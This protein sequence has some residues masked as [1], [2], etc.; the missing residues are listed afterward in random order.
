MKLKLLISILFISVI[1]HPMYSM[2]IQ[3]GVSYTIEQARKIAFRN[4]PIKI[5]M[6]KY[7][8][9]LIDKNFEKNKTFISKGELKQKKYILTIFA[10]NSYVIH[11]KNKKT[12]YYY[13]KDGKLILIE[14]MS[15][16]RY[17]YKSV[18]YNS[19]GDLD[20]ISLSVDSNNEFIF[21][22]NKKLYAHWIGNNCYNAKG[23][24]IDIRQSQY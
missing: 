13:Q 23:E 21:D 8:K 10:D 6:E 17:P 7:Q 11:Y 15:N 3:G 1:T 14:F 18:R 2:T 12:S 4:T 9:Y 22:T 19:N 24:L 5:N 20:S 16:H